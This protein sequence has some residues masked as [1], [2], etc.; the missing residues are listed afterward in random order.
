MS[1]SKPL[2]VKA[3]GSIPHL[4]ESRLGPGD[5]QC[6]PGQAR[7]ATRKTRDRHDQVIVQEKLDGSNV[8]IANIDGVIVPLV[9]SGYVANTSPYK[10]HHLFSNWVYGQVDRFLSLL[11]PG[12]RL[13]GEWLAQ[14]HGTRYALTHDPFVGFDLMV[15][16]TRLLY[17][18]FVARTQAIDLVTPTL[19]H[20]G[21][22]A[23]GVDQALRAIAV[24]GHGAIDPVEGAVWRVER[25]GVVEF[26]VKYVRSDKADGC[27]LSSVTG[28][29]EVWNL[30]PPS[31]QD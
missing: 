15:G 26:L 2:G 18:D 3:Y 23:F 31:V 24:S 20:Q 21:P 30:V 5:H 14:A 25:H 12:E 16:Q 17:T 8:A 27:Y 22:M 10:Q 7:I 11:Q 28:Q 19:L 4:P 9:R 13:C 1:N 6:N 29:P